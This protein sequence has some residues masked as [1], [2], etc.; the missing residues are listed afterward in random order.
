M[1]FDCEVR[2]VVLTSSSP[3]HRSARN[4]LD[5]AAVGIVIFVQVTHREV[6]AH[7]ASLLSGMV[8]A[9]HARCL[10]AAHV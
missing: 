9:L 2:N 6:L 10:S 8:I 7:V 1:W 4:M 3:L 5:P